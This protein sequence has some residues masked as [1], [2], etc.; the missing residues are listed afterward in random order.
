MAGMIVMLSDP[1]M[2]SVANIMA[3]P[4]IMPGVLVMLCGP[5]FSGEPQ[6]MLA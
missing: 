4:E 2:I 5:A 6:L 1:I 3:M